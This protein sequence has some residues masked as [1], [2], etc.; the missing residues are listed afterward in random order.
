MRLWTLFPCS[1]IC[2]RARSRSLRRR[3]C[4]SIWP[5]LLLARRRNRA[6]R[7]RLRPLNRCRPLLRHRTL[8][9][10]SLPLRRRLGVTLRCLPVRC[11]LLVLGP[12]YRCGSLLLRHRL[13]LARSRLRSHRS[14][15][16]RRICARRPSRFRRRLCASGCFIRTRLR[17]TLVSLHR[18]PPRVR[19]LHPG[20]LSVPIVVCRRRPHVAIGLNRLLVHH[21]LRTTVI[22]LRK[23]LPDLL[24]LLHML[25]LR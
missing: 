9:S 5:L 7:P 16:P 13:L 18:S 15:R 1:R 23:V 10:R 24:R 19:L 2:M 3:T 12:L 4:F 25:Q 21:H 14:N 22:H 6:F 20:Q 17:C 11:W 8:D